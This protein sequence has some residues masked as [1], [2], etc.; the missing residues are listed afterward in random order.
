MHQ[1]STQPLRLVA[2]MRQWIASASAD[3]L[4]EAFRQERAAS[5]LMALKYAQALEQ[6]L[7]VRTLLLQLVNH[8]H[9]KGHPLYGQALEVLNRSAQVYRSGL[10]LPARS[11]ETD[12]PNATSILDTD[13]DR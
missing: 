6:V 4:R 10:D 12:C 8:P 1:H 9:S 11:V 3:E 5:A 7:A 13:S 2:D